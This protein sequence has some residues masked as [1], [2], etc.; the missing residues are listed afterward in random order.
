MRAL[1]CVAKDGRL[2]IWQEPHAF[3]SRHVVY[4]LTMV[5]LSDDSPLKLYTI[6]ALDPRDFGREVLGVW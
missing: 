3:K 4:Y 2:E 5:Y 1:V 6:H